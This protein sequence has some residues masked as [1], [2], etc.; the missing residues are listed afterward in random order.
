MR[1]WSVHQGLSPQS[2]VMVPLCGCHVPQIWFAA[3]RFTFYS[4][5]LSLFVLCCPSELEW[6][7]FPP[8]WLML[9]DVESFLCDHIKAS[10]KR[11]I[12]SCWCKLSSFNNVVKC[13]S[14]SLL[15][16]LFVH[17]DLLIQRRIN[18]YLVSTAVLV[19]YCPPEWEWLI[20]P[21]FAY[22]IST[23]FLVQ[24]FPLLIQLY[25]LNNLLMCI[26]R[27]SLFAI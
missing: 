25:A 22:Q 4:T 1:W 7:L 11:L 16:S 19:Q 3:H 13:A 9:V 24:P 2:C 15:I 6:I 8:F 18:F 10:P 23:S 27:Y 26:S 20:V 14:R 12:H 17:F 5:I 21:W